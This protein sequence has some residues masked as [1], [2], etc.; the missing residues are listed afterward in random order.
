MKA[1]R[2]FL[3][4]LRYLNYLFALLVDDQ[5]IIQQLQMH[6]MPTYNEHEYS[7]GTGR[8]SQGKCVQLPSNLYFEQVLLGTIFLL[9]FC[10]HQ[11]RF[12]KMNLCENNHMALTNN[13]EKKLSNV[14]VE[15]RQKRLPIR[16]NKHI[17]CF[18]GLNRN[19]FHFIFGFSSRKKNV[20]TI[21][22]DSMIVMIL[23]TIC[24]I[25]KY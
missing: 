1:H 17:S 10:M 25:P 20:P 14:S 3:S 24:T 5:Y 8:F 23:F 7:R 16:N 22:F 6:R 11:F 2:F 21:R 13:S 9:P 19:C 18:F 12:C 4:C 15:N